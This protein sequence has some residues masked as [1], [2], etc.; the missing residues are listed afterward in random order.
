M[1]NN[2]QTG[3]ITM[4]ELCHKMDR[5]YDYYA[6]SVG[7]NFTT[8]MVLQYLCDSEKTQTKKTQK[9]LCETLGMPKQLV[10][11]IIKSF[12]EQGYVRLKEAKDRRNKEIIVTDKGQEFATKILKP[13][14]DAEYAVWDSFTYDEVLNLSKSLEKYATVFEGILKNL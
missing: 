2:S 4:K 13:L 1:D 8:L 10:N 3:S 14:D 11:S 9:E 7:L 6:K 5:L 12:W